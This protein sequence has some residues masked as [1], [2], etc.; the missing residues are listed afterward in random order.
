[1]PTINGAAIRMVSTRKA[2]P[3]SSPGPK[4][5]WT[6]IIPTG[7]SPASCTMAHSREPTMDIPAFANAS[8]GRGWPEPEYTAWLAHSLRAQ[9]LR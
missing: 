9:L 1:V 2:M 7:R 3:T 4:C 5:G 8:T 6:P